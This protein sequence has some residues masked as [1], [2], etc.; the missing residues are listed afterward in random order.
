MR[1]EKD[2]LAMICPD[3]QLFF[4]PQSLGVASSKDRELLKKKIKEIRTNLE[5]EK[6]IQEKERKLKEKEQKKM[7][8]KK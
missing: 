1:R 7:S 8:K 4:C 3:L 6:K 5:R 2:N